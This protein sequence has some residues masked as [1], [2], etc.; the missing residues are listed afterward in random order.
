MKLPR[1]LAFFAALPF[2]VL[3]LVQGCSGGSSGGVCAVLV[4]DAGP[5]DQGSC[6]S[7]PKQGTSC[8]ISSTASCASTLPLCQSLC[9]PAD[10]G[11][12]VVP[13]PEAGASDADAFEASTFDAAKPDGATSGCPGNKQTA[14]LLNTTCQTALEKSCCTE[15]K[16][17][18]NMASGTSSDCNAY[19]ACLDSC[20]TSADVPTCQSDCGNAST[21]AIVSAYDA[22]VTCATNN[23]AA[24]CQ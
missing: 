6:A 21:P 13:R 2:A 18:F 9:C 1:N 23:A 19:T 8:C 5:A 24:E 7:G 14:P 16:G 12:V 3:V 22:I 11:S 4:D 15:L 10:G 17:C 20:S